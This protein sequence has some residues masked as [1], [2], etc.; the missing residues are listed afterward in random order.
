VSLSRKTAPPA[1]GQQGRPRPAWLYAL[2]GGKL[3][4]TLVCGGRRFEHVYTYK[5]DFFAATGL[6]NCGTEL[7]VLKLGRTTPFLGLP[8]GWAGRF[9]E[10]RELKLLE[11]VRD[12]PGVPR[13]IGRVGRNGLLREF[14]PGHPL[15]RREQVSDQFFDELRVLLSRLHARDV[16]YVDLNKRQNIL[17]G[18][19]GRPYLI[20][21]HIALCLPAAGWRGLVPVRWL[22]ARFQRA[23]DYHYLKHKRRLRPDLLT[24]AEHAQLERISIWIKI[25]R[26]VA[27]P[28]TH[29]RRRALSRLQKTESVEVPGSGAK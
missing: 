15:G 12:V 17:V 13:V 8:M 10:G 1:A 3:P 23:D 28:L 19:D 16:A 2:P 7:A 21:F 26:C 9:L 29:L 4:T 24:A 5:H 22:L 27:R 25:H 14:V 20:D 6:Y 11:Y 18:D